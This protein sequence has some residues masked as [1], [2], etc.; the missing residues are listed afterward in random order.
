[1]TLSSKDVE[2]L[3]AHFDPIRTRL[4]DYRD[5]IELAQ[6]F[7]RHTNEQ[8][9]ECLTEKEAKMMQKVEAH[10]I[11][12]QR[13][14]DKRRRAA[15]GAA[16]RNN[17]WKENALG[18]GGG[19]SKRLTAPIEKQ[20]LGMR[21]KNRMGAK[22]RDL[23]ERVAT[24]AMRHDKKSRRPARQ[25]SKNVT[26][27]ELPG[28]KRVL[29]AQSDFR[30]RLAQDYD[31]KLSPVEAAI[32]EKQFNLRQ[33]GLV[34]VKE[35]E[36]FFKGLGET[37]KARARKADN[38]KAF[39][40]ASSSGRN[41]DEGTLRK[42]SNNRKVGLKGAAAADSIQGVGGG[43]GG[44]DFVPEAGEA[45]VNKEGDEGEETED[46][47]Y[48]PYDDDEFDDIGESSGGMGMMQNAVSLDLNNL[49][50]EKD[51]FVD[52]DDDAEEGGAA[53]R[54]RSIIKDSVRDDVDYDND[55]DTEIA[56]SVADEE[57]THQRRQPASPQDS[58]E[59]S[60]GDDDFDD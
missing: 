37:A 57:A 34:D 11:M 6:R 21:G 22:H 5:L 60:Y 43:G 14:K 10:R 52:D 44:D 7:T 16:A 38:Q 1:M 28:K 42:I 45:M 9:S 56:S 50:G 32:L 46:D 12:V 25:Q 54:D 24:A 49:G 18:V 20:G 17:K 41:G 51:I 59:D 31:L 53:G 8:S 33:D 58:S 26:G 3:I 39:L 13:N 36:K 40:R 48:N 27:S 19:A 30:K 35:W 55:C 4:I 23:L 2:L 15:E 29:V 47:S